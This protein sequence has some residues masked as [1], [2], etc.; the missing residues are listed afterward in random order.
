MSPFFNYPDSAKYGRMVPKSKIYEHAKASI[1]LKD[2]FIEQVDKITW[3]YKLAPETINI[4]ATRSVPEIQVFEIRL[5]S[6]ALHKDILTAIDKA[7][8]FPLIFELVHGDRRKMVATY[9]RQNEADKSKWVISDHLESAWHKTPVERSSLPPTLDLKALYEKL[10]APLF[11]DEVAPEAPM[12]ARID[13][14]EE[15]K[16]QR[17]EVEN[18][19]AKL[20]KE[21]QF[22]K[23][24]AINATLR[25]AKQKL[26]ELEKLDNISRAEQAI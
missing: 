26:K 20:K 13:R 14:L 1:R 22:K 15:I 16:A 10:L 18:I 19:E 2:L 7:I 11:P 6:N 21:K 12:Q 24:V 5:K 9:K 23:K 3:A 25:D 17:R 4:N 8:P